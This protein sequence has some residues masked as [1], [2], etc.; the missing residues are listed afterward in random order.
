MSKV[1]RVLLV[2]LLLVSMISLVSV[3]GCG[4]EEAAPE[5]AEPTPE[6]TGLSQLEMEQILADS[7]LAIMD[8]QTYK[9]I[10]D[11]TMAMEIQGGPEEGSATTDMNM[12]G[13]YDQVNQSMRMTMDMTIDAGDMG[14]GE[15]PESITIEMYMLDEWMYMHMDMPPL[16]DQWMKMPV[17]E[18]M[19][20]G[21]AGSFGADMIEQQLGPL[22]TPA[23]IKYLREEFFDGSN[24][25][26]FEIVPDMSKI[27]DWLDQQQLA[28]S[29][30]PMD[31]MD[32]VADMFKE[33]I[34]ITWVDKETKYMR[35]MDAKIVMDISSEDVGAG[36]D[37]GDM[38]MDITM[39][40]NIYDYNVPVTITLPPEAEDAMEMPF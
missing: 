34:Y 2:S 29:G 20:Q 14:M 17:T 27:M 7:M 18:E 10:M 39:S 40:M 4:E 9:F 23:E 25:Y 13:R 32:M 26:V 16:G 37:M 3:F 6:A 5:A 38:K 21:M 35:K 30:I 28:E 33:L 15:A 11:M 22:D 19:A 31:D 8:V 24:C 1:I 36:M 12:S